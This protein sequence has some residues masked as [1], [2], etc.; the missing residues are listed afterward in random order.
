MSIALAII[1]STAIVCGTAMVTVLG[2]LGI[3]HGHKY[4]EIE[5]QVKKDKADKKAEQK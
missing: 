2:A 1:I 3:I 5:R 4:A